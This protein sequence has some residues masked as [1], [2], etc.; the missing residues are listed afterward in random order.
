M[1]ASGS[2]YPAAASSA[3]P[4][5][6][7][8]AAK[9]ARAGL[10]RARRKRGRI[11]A[12][13][14]RQDLCVSGRSRPASGIPHRVVVRDRQ[15][16]R[17]RRRGLWRAVDAVSSGDR[18]RARSRRL[19]QPADLDGPRRGDPRRHPPLQRNI[20]ARRRRP[21]R[22]R[23][24]AVSRLDRCLGDA[25]ARADERRQHRAARTQARRVPISAT[26][27][28]STP[29]GR[30]CCRAMPATAANRSANRP[31]IITASRFFKVTGRL[32]IDDKP[33]DVT[34]QAWMDREWSS[35]PLASDQTGW[36][37]FSLHFDVRRKADAVPDAPDRRQALRLRQLD[38]AR[39]HDRTA[40]LR[41]HHA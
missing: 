16:R 18:R 17:R 20:C 40:R 33:V 25:R 10:C 30:W 31:P 2:I 36:D 38:R 1:S 24:Q 23:G 8:S 6:L 14:S 4:L 13:R 39:R 9:R 21:G 37:W 15:S 11:C 12:G 7:G 41:R 32:T 28:G 5:A 26:R 27:C 29:I 22:R 34:G 19:G 35:Q 3:A